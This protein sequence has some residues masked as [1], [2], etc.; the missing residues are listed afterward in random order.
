MEVYFFF[1]ILC[2]CKCGNLHTRF[3]ALMFFMWWRKMGMLNFSYNSC[4]TLIWVRIIPVK[5]DQSLPGRSRI[6]F[7]IPFGYTRSTGKRN[8]SNGHHYNVFWP[9]GTNIISPGK[10]SQSKPKHK[11]LKN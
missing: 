10:N 3:L 11:K 5:V 8:L 6:Y 4:G 2:L 7:I 1:S 9:W